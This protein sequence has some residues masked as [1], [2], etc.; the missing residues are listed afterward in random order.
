[1]NTKRNKI[2]KIV[3]P[4]LKD[5]SA[6]I[7]KMD[8]FK[9][10]E[11]DENIS[12]IAY[13]AYDGFIP[14]TDGGLRLVIKSPVYNFINM[15]LIPAHTRF[16]LKLEDIQESAIEY[17]DTFDSDESDYIMHYTLDIII[18]VKFYKADNYSNPTN[19]DPNYTKPIDCIQI[20][21]FIELDG[22]SIVNDIEGSIIDCTTINEDFKNEANLKI[23]NLFNFINNI[24][25]N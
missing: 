6:S 17:A 1:M 25:F 16:G 15:G 12:E 14:F 19:N 23:S 2:N 20:D 22:L 11:N 3:N 18:N 7:F 24:L 4:I 5:L 10:S 8:L 13:K 21:C 9:Y